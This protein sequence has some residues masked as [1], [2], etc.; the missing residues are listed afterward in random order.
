MSST[1]AP[2]KVRAV[3]DLGGAVA[4]GH[5]VT[6]TTAFKAGF[7]FALGVATMAGILGLAAAIFVG[8]GL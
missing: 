5:V 8:L 6:L 2:L 1:K 3:A 4:V 7:G